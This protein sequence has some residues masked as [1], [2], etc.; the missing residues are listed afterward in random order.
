MHLFLIL[1]LCGTSVYQGLTLHQGSYSSHR[2]SALI[3]RATKYGGHQP[4]GGENQNQAHYAYA[5]M[6]VR[7]WK[8]GMQDLSVMRFQILQS[9][10]ICVKEVSHIKY[11]LRPAHQVPIIKRLSINMQYY[12][13]LACIDLAAFADLCKDVMDAGHII[14]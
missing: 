11:I 1:I 13:S 12:I 8:P 9:L 4:F 2:D 7:T 3:D 14:M 5:C 6:H 10:K